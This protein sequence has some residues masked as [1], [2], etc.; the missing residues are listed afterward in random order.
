MPVKREYQTLT[1]RTRMMLDAPE[2]TNVD[3]K[4]EAPGIKSSDLVAFANSP[5]G[6]TLL[7]G[8]D[9]YTSED[10]L[11][12]GKIVGCDVDDNARLMMINKATDCYPNVEIQI[13]IENLNGPPLMRVEVPSGHMRPYCSSR[14]E[15]TVRTEGRN[16]ALYPEELLLIFMD[17]EG[18]K[19][20]TRFKTAVS[21]LEDKVG[22]INQSLSHDMGTVA[23]HIH[24]LDS[25]L[26]KTLGHVG[27]LT[28]S[29]KKR[30]RNLLQTLKDS[31][32]SIEKLE[33]HLLAERH[34]VAD[35]YQRDQQK[36]LAS[37]ESKLD[38][39]LDRLEVPLRD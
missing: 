34:L 15:Y 3:F 20:L 31:H 14:G 16:R 27:R 4:R 33:Q 37:L 7:I 28:D 26:Q 18:D 10:G 17:R 30:S 21:Q 6:G 5:T 25:Q 36:R 22:H 9:E 24:D 12:R 29:S 38:V 19:F 32:D 35:N 8:V 1:K 11:Q 39:L 13:F 2:N 23:Q